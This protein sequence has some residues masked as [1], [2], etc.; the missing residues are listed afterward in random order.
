MKRKEPP[1]N[2][3]ENLTDAQCMR[4]FA[5]LD[6]DQKRRLISQLPSDDIARVNYVDPRQYRDIL[7]MISAGI[8]IQTWGRLK[9][10]C[11]YFN[12]RLL[13]PL[14]IQRIRQSKRYNL[15]DRAQAFF[16]WLLRLQSILNPYPLMH[17]NIAKQHILNPS[18]IR[19]SVPYKGFRVVYPQGFIV[20]NGTPRGTIFD[21]NIERYLFDTSTQPFKIVPARKYNKTMKEYRDNA[22][23]MWMQ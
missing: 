11:S 22:Y 12:Q 19:K 2:S 6:V 20:I 14:I 16:P 8:D 7:P 3:L 9:R 17:W 13:V 23:K 5:Y 15:D 21:E 1:N 18:A 4:A 10:A